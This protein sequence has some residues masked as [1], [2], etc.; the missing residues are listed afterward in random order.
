MTFKLSLRHYPWILAALL[1]MPWCHSTAAAPLPSWLQVLLPPASQVAL[2]VQD[3]RTQQVLLSHNPDVQMLPA[4]T[5]KLLT[6][7][8]AWEVLGADYRFHTRILTTGTIIQ[9]VLQGNLYL[10]FSGDPRLSRQQ[11][12]QMAQTLRQQGLEKINGQLFL[13]GNNSRQW[14]AP[15]WV[16]DD[17]GICYAAPI[18]SFVI[19]GNCIKARLQQTKTR[20]R[21]TLLTPA[22]VSVTSSAFFDPQQQHDFCQLTLHRQD[23]NHYQLSGCY[24][25]RPPLPLAIAVSNP[26]QYAA[27]VIAA[28]YRPQFH[29][30]GPVQFA[31]TV[32]DDATLLLD[33]PSLPL[34]TLIGEMLLDSDNLIADTLLKQLGSQRLG[35]REQDAVFLAGGQQ[36]KDTLAGMGIELENSH[37]IDGSGLSRYNLLSARQLGQLLAQIQQRPTLRWLLDA[38]PKSGLSGTLHHKAPFN[39]K[40]LRGRI[41]AKT[42]SMQGVQ[43]LAGF[44][45]GDAPD[46]KY[47]YLFV[48]MENGH[49]TTDM[50]DSGF[51]GQVLLQLQQRLG[52]APGMQKP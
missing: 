34:S 6:A 7:V 32:P 51:I 44:L 31:S 16:W 22:P 1:A 52:N 27:D 48:I 14:R 5:Q 46:D 37:I 3:T 42:G 50:P 18:S 4:S 28:L 11:L 2:W 35:P 21:V 13:V 43:N 29:F 49:V 47:R 12:S 38:L 30:E 40:A 33:H 24:G 36:I 25:K 41:T 15:G 39:Q 10:Q 20:T 23:D 19:D 26:Q 17:L 9:G 45:S 8:T